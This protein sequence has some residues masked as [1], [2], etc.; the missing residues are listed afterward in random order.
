MIGTYGALKTLMLCLQSAPT[1]TGCSVAFGEENKRA[2]DFALPYVCVVPGSGVFLADITPGY[3]K[4]A[5]VYYNMIWG[6]RET[7]DLWLWANSTVEGAEPVDHADAIENFRARVL[8]ALQ[9][10]RGTGLFY[11]AISGRW[12]HASDAVDR[13]GR[14]YVI[15]VEAEI[16]IPD[17]LPT[18]VTVQSVTLQPEIT[19]EG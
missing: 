18:E 19:V 3:I 13:F 8:Q 10:Q 1:L 16:S 4:D 5:N 7:C 2:Q 9:H 17:V 6:L 12:E 11:K 14:A 15:T